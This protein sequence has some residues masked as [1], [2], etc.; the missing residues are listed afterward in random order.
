MYVKRAVNN[1]NLWYTMGLMA[2]TEIPFQGLD[3]LFSRR[4]RS[5]RGGQSPRKPSPQQSFIPSTPPPDGDFRFGRRHVP[6]TVVGIL[7]AGGAAVT[8]TKP[9]ERFAQPETL[10][11]LVTQ[12]KKMEDEYKGKDL[13]DKRARERYADILSGIFAFHYSEYF[14]R[15]QLKETIVWADTLDQFVR[16]RNLAIGK[17]GNPSAQ[18]LENERSTTASTDN[19]A[20]KITVN[21]ASDVFKQQNI[22][23]MNNLPPNWNPL[24]M[25]RIS[26]LHE[27]NH[28]VQET[29]DD[30]VF[31]VVDPENRITNKRIEGFRFKGTDENGNF[32][33]GLNDLHEAVMELLAKDISQI[34]F[35]SHF[36]DYQ[37]DVTGLSIT[38]IMNTLEQ[39]LQVIG[40]SHKD[41]A[42][43]HKSS[44][45]REFSLMLSD[46]AG[47]NTAESLDNRLRFGINIASA[48]ERNNQRLLQG[49]INQVLLA[50]NST[51]S[52]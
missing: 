28:L 37:D 36:S 4:H 42:K 23:S 45:L 7:I 10:D 8:L 19:K 44:N 16:Q 33:T 50:Q 51:N 35:G 39:I 52:R 2:T 29:T 40:L 21:A 20:K 47:V 30:A 32:A 27:F 11:N 1:K 18:Q 9:W 43:L 48:I 25:L 6:L 49:Y 5:H 12:A 31:S 14:S 22:R 26:L 3:A 34:D 41:L 17:V 46:K 38:T 24:K 13:S 15:Q